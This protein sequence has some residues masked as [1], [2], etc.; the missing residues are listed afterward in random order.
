MTFTD[1]AEAILKAAGQP[2]HY[3]K[4]TEIAIANNLLSHVGK[5]P[6]VTMSSRLATMVRKDRG[7]APIVK[8]RPGVFGLREF[9]E[10]V[11][12][13]DEN[14]MR[15]DA[16]QLAESIASLVSSRRAMDSE[17]ARD[18][19]DRPSVERSSAISD[20]AAQLFPE[21]ADDDDPILGSARGG[22]SSPEPADG[23]TDDESSADSASRRGRRSR[24]SRR[25]NRRGRRGEEEGSQANDELDQ[26]TA[27]EP[28]E[29]PHGARGSELI[30]EIA[31]AL[32]N[33]SPRRFVP[34]IELAEYLEGKKRLAGKPEDLVTTLRAALRAE[35]ALTLREGRLPRFRLRGLE[36]ALR[37]GWIGGETVRLQRQARMLFA[38]HNE[39]VRQ[40]FLRRLCDLPPSG[41]MELLAA[42]LNAEGVSGL[43]A[44]P[45]APGCAGEHFLA[46]K[47]CLPGQELRLVVMIHRCG[48]IMPEHVLSARGALPHYDN[49]GALWLVG[50]GRVDPEAYAESRLPGA[51]PCRILDGSALVEAM[52]RVGVGMRHETCKLTYIDLELFDEIG[53]QRRTASGEGSASEALP[54]DLP[55]REPDDRDEE[56]RLR[57]KTRRRRGS[58]RRTEGSGETDAIEQ[59]AS[60]A[61]PPFDDEEFDEPQDD[62]SGRGQESHDVPSLPDMESDAAG[63]SSDERQSSVQ[64]ASS[65]RLD[66]ATARAPSARQAATAKTEVAHDAA[67]DPSGGARGDEV[68]EGDTEP[69]RPVVSPE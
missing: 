13:I 36:V 5:T 31:A 14:Q 60:K 11:A 69:L 66:A 17:R 30:E 22:G 33:E 59:D 35:Q 50:I 9:S 51:A 25:S 10:E 8:V 15:L 3:R 28:A 68:T 42:W 61:A 24:R 52:E 45:R 16:K 4:L 63:Q 29:L 64:N 37:Q 47:L 27:R 26:P 19:E 48:A 56:R 20:Y 62:A 21:E 57:R 2:L 54:R 34:L 39:S 32:D 1:A 18:D 38:Q 43:R 67:D 53:S 65:S 55:R 23:K 6:E 40:T 7:E 46:G 12:K 44:L 49:A 58:A 41:L